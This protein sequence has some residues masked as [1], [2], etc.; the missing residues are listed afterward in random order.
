MSESGKRNCRRWVPGDRTKVSQDDRPD[1]DRDHTFHPSLG[2]I[3]DQGS[4][5]RVLTLSDV[6]RVQKYAREM[7]MLA[8][9]A[10]KKARNI[11]LSEEDTLQDFLNNCT[12][13]QV[14]INLGLLYLK[15]A[16]SGGPSPE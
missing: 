3:P 7:I 12:E 14:W 10:A 9:E 13:A 15:L 16:E 11:F 6:S 8:E 5:F 2:R 1:V 4:A